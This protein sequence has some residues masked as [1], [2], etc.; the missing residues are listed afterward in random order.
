MITG[1][2]PC[3]ADRDYLIDFISELKIKCFKFE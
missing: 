3:I 2:Y 1:E